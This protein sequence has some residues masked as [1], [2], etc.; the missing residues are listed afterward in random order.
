MLAIMDAQ[1]LMIVAR[2]KVPLSTCEF[3]VSIAFVSPH[4]RSLLLASKVG[5]ETIFLCW[6]IFGKREISFS[7]THEIIEHLR[8]HQTKTWYCWYFCNSFRRSKF[9][10][11]VFFCWVNISISWHARKKHV[12]FVATHSHNSSIPSTCERKKNCYKLSR[13]YSMEEQCQC[14]SA[15][16]CKWNG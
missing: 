12:H 13:Q 10:C 3:T 6:I 5:F 9:F 8:V 16:V 14:V 4:F 1:Q 11:S 15:C 2:T 7:E